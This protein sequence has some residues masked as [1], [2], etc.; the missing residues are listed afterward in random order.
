MA[1]IGFD[2]REKEAIGSGKV[3]GK[4]ERKIDIGLTYY[5]FM[6]KYLRIAVDSLSVKGLE[7]ERNFASL[8]CA[9][10]YFRIHNF[11]NAIL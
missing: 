1:H 4:L 2:Q 8:F 7:L 10:A 9:Y 11:R 3:G 6:S 5:E